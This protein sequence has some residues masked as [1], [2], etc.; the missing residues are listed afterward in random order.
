MVSSDPRD[1]TMKLMKMMN[2][3]MERFYLG[4]LPLLFLQYSCTLFGSMM[5][6]VIDD[7]DGFR[8]CLLSLDVVV[9]VVGDHE[10]G[11]GIN[12]RRL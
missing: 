6:V 3:M 4:C 12:N 9:V 8:S 7:G 10:E 5:V 11:P 2:V 1:E